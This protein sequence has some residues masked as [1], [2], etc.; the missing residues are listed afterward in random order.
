MGWK[1]VQ[2]DTDPVFSL[3]FLLEDRRDGSFFIGV[4]CD[5]PTHALLGNARAREIW[6]NEVLMRTVPAIFRVSSKSWLEEPLEEKARLHAAISHAY[7]H[8]RN[9]S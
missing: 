8:R 7:E 4:E 3:D 9:M 2:N 5:S 1:V 6:R